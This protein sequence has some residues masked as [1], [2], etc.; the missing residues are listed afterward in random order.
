M[1]S[2]GFHAYAPAVGRAN[3]RTERKLNMKDKSEASFAPDWL[4]PRN[5]RKTPYT[6]A[7]LD[8]FVDDFIARMSDTEAWKNLVAEVGEPKARDV[9]KHR[10]AA[11]DAK[12]L[13]DWQA[14]G[15]LN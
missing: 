3:N 13:F 7:E 12:S 4:D 14:G 10:L 8:I 15:R 5:D 9:L 1:A 11:Q 2:C 6:D